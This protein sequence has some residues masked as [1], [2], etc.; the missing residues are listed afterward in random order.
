MMKA[1][2]FVKQLMKVQGANCLFYV[3]EGTGRWLQPIDADDVC[4]RIVEK[5]RRVTTK[6]NGREFINELN[7]AHNLRGESF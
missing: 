1:R 6:V 2:E 3:V 7:V 4:G 5:G